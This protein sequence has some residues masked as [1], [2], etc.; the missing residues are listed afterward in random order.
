MDECACVYICMYVCAYVCM[1]ACMHV[2]MH[3]CV[4]Y[5]S[6]HIASLQMPQ[7]ST[8]HPITRMN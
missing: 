4:L 7:S 1:H 3:V 8:H 6:E 2:Y 5:S